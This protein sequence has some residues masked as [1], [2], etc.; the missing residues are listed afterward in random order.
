MRDFARIGLAVGPQKTS[1][2]V[3]PAPVSRVGYDGELFAR[4]CDS[5]CRRGEMDHHEARPAAGYCG[6]RIGHRPGEAEFAPSADRVAAALEDV[7]ADGLARASMR[8][9]HAVPGR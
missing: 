3:G 2:L 5:Y 6:A 8:H 1:R 7:G 4:V 9:H